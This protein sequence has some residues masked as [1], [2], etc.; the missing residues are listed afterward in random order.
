MTSEILI[1]FALS[2]PLV[3]ASTIAGVHLAPR[4]PETLVRRAAFGLLVM[5]GAFLIF[6]SLQ[7]LSSIQIVSQ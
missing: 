5:L 3:V 4:V 6:Q 1:T 7:S 2:V